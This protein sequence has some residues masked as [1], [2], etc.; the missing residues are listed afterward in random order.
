L[1]CV[2]WPAGEYDP[3]E[4]L[5]ASDA[6]YEEGTIRHVRVSNFEPAHVDRAREVLDVPVVAN[7]V[8]MHPLFQ[9]DHL[10]AYAAETDLHLVAYSPLA[11]G[12]VFEVSTLSEIAAAHGLSEARVSLAWLREKGV[13]AIPK[14]TR[15]RRTSGTTSGARRSRCATTNSHAS[16]TPTGLTGR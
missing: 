12:R 14:A 6:L 4:T 16:T 3:E 7:Q 8:E 10:R 1:L 11:G 15:A 9:Q 2:H 13:S 5:A